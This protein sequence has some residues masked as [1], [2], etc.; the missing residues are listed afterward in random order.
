MTALYSNDGG[1]GNQTSGYN[2]AS[3]A[4]FPIG[5]FND[6]G[7]LSGLSGANRLPTQWLTFNGP[8]LFN[9]ITQQ[10][11]G[12]NGFTTFAPP[13]VSDSLVVERVFG[14]YLETT[15]AGTLLDRPFAAVVGVRV[16]DTQET[17]NGLSTAYTG[18]TKLLNDPTQFGVASSGTTTVSSSN[19]YTDVLPTMSFKW[20][21]QDNFLARFAASQTMTRPTLEDLSP[22]FTLVT[23][24]PGDYAASSGNAQ[25]QPF[26]SNNLD[27]SFEYYFSDA[28][29]LSLGGYTRTSA[30]SLS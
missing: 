19:S 28:D 9:A 13:K 18:L 27:L 21:L 17:V 12:I 8:A 24:R 30:T 1:T 16:E 3:P 29:Y 10:Q 15:F 6:G 2:I 25:L 7:I 14:G 4:G 20:Q 5:V 22:V 26:R 11:Q 23:L